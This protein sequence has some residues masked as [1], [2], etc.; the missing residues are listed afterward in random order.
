MRR[1]GPLK[2]GKPLGRGKPLQAKAGL[3]RS[4]SPR[5]VGKPLAKG[6]LRRAP[7]S[8]TTRSPAQKAQESQAQLL[9]RWHTC[10]PGV[11][12]CCG[13]APTKADPME[14]HHVLP[15]QYI[16]KYV[17]ALKLTKPARVQLLIDLLWDR[18]NGMPLLQSCH[19]RHTR[20]IQRVP[21]RCLRPQHY[22]FAM[23]L[24]MEHVLDRQYPEGNP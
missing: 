21:R 2:R 10:I 23:A 13:K 8:N 9:W 14:A 7:N 18:R 6:V 11:C 24:G 19:R 15:K 3:A 4:M 17:A 22:E 12:A 20:A 5:G 16:K 1:S